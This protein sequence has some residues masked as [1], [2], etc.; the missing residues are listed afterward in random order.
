MARGGIIM[1]QEK[2]VET[3]AVVNKEWD[4][5]HIG[6]ISISFSKDNEKDD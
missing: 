5:E 2:Y 4:S 6:K 3:K 1:G